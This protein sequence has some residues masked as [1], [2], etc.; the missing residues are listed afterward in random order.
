MKYRR[1][2]V[3]EKKIGR[4]KY[5]FHSWCR[6]LARLNA[7]PDKAVYIFIP[8]N[9][10]TIDMDEFKQEINDEICAAFLEIYGEKVKPSVR[11]GIV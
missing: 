1:F 9:P 2:T 6:V 11:R 3:V 4:S 8:F 10:E 7:D 5:W